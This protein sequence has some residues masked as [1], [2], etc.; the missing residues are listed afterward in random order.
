MYSLV[1]RVNYHSIRLYQLGVSF[2]SRICMAENHYDVFPFIMM[3][4]HYD[5]IVWSQDE[6]I[7]SIADMIYERKNKPAVHLVIYNALWIKSK[8]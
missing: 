4:N 2:K 7:R 8:K 5:V 1:F 3:E 6:I